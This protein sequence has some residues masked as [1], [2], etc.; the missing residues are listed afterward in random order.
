[1]RQLK[2]VVVVISILIILASV[3]LLPIGLPEVTRANGEKS[4]LSIHTSFDGGLSM[5]FIETAKPT[6][7]KLLGGPGDNCWSLAAEIKQKSPSTLIIGRIYFSDEPTDGDAA[8]RAS[9]WWDRCR[10]VIENCPAVDYWEGYNE[11][12]V[13]T[14]EQMRWIAQF[15]VARIRILADH[16][17]KACIGSFSTGCPEIVQDGRPYD[18]I[19]REF[20]SAID[21]ANAHGG[22]LGLHEYSAPTMNDGFDSASGEGWLTGRYRKV[23]RWFLE[24]TGRGHTPLI[25]TECGIDG[26][27]IGRPN[28]GWKSFATKEQYFEQLKW[29]DSLLKQDYYV[30]GATIFCLEI[31]NWQSFDIAE[32]MPELTRYVAGGGSTISGKVALQGRSNHAGATV[33]AGSVSV[34]TRSDGTFSIQVTPGTYEVRVT[35]PGYLYATKSISVSE[36]QTKDLGSITLLG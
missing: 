13:G 18:G 5:S 11:P 20:Y 30:L 35:M 2:N 15:E 14:V 19:W 29:Y 26:G 31:P 17:R 6:V 1:M 8:R 36:G 4:K 23:Y 25:I 33:T 16:G 32:L 34:R 12:P 3:F 21:E 24:P 9:D 27:V 28:E 10:D 7:V 22:V